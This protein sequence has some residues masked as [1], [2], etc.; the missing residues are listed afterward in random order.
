MRSHV[1]LFGAVVV[2]AAGTVW[3]C[4]SDDEGTGIVTQSDGG[5]GSSTSSSGAGSSSGASSSGGSSSGS[6]GTNDGGTSS[7]ALGGDGGIDPPDAGPGGDTTKV[8]CGATSCALATDLCCASELGG[9]AR[10]YGCANAD[11]GCP[12]PS[13]GGDVAALTCSAQANCPAN[14]VCCVRQTGAGAASACKAACDG[15]EA[16]L[17]DPNATDAG[18]PQSDPC[19]NDNIGDWVL[20]DTYATCGGKGNG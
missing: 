11:A 20:P 3:A 4:G 8:N 5:G 7:G 2:G 6:S 18:C 19:S 16:Q 9:G 14:T 10:A 15:N 1:L 12:A 13:G 17:C